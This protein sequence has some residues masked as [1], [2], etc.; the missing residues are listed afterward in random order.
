VCFGSDATDQPEAAREIDFSAHIIFA[1]SRA[2]R[3]AKAIQ[4]RKVIRLRAN[5]EMPVGVARR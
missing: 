4:R 2:I 5:R 3:T 1:A